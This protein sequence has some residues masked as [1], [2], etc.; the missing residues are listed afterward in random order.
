MVANNLRKPKVVSVVGGGAF[1]TAMAQL[2]GRQGIET[3]MWVME[4]HAR[5][6]INNEHENKSFLP[7]CPL[8]KTIKAYGSVDE[9][10][11]NTEMVLLV[12]PTPFFRRWL[13]ANHSAFPSN[14]PLVL[15]SKGIENDTLVTPYEI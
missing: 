6:A 4:D 12:V 9:A 7:G 14:V 3:R 13:K 10:F 11:H 15:C 5:D 1:G 2:M 8:A